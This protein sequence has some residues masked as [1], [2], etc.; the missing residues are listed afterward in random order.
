MRSTIDV[1]ADWVGGIRAE[2]GRPRAKILVRGAE[3]CEI[4]STDIA[5]FDATQTRAGEVGNACDVELRGSLDG[6][7]VR[8]Y[9]FWKRSDK[10][11]M[12]RRRYLSFG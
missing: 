5:S 1:E 11:M 9:S 8:L 4:L 10:P 2:G 3:G 6:M 7:Y 12:P